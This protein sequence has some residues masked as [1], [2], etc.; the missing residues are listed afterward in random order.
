MGGVGEGGQFLE[1]ICS[2]EAVHIFVGCIVLMPT[3]ELEIKK[4]L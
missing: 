2:A 1:L 3:I 4:F